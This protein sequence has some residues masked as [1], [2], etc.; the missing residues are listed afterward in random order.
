GKD[1]EYIVTMQL[2]IK[3]DTGDKTGQIV[4]QRKIPELKLEDIKKIIPEI[5]NIKEQVPHK[6]SAVKVN[7]KRAYQLA[8]EDKQ[9]KLKSRPI[10]ILEFSIEEFNLP[11][12]TYKTIV[13]KGT[14][15]RSLTETIAEKLN[16]IATSVEL[17][18]T[19][20]GNLNIEDAIDLEKLNKNNWKIYLQS[21]PDIFNDIQ[22]YYVNVGELDFFRNGRQFKVKLE[23]RDEIMILNENDECVGF[24]SI[25]HN[26]LKPRIVLV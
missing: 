15:I 14:Y 20:I 19:K 2:G 13:S 23:N 6:F 11:N 4:E 1:K 12:I 5:L 17:K 24:A 18:R 3:T 26:T 25:E 7:G 10:R 9:I 8:R 16:T 22:K 21:L